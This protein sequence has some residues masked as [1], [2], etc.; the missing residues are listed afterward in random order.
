MYIYFVTS[1]RGRFNFQPSYLTVLQDG[2]ATEQVVVTLLPLGAA[3]CLVQRRLKAPAV[4]PLASVVISISSGTPGRLIIF[5]KT[6][7]SVPTSNQNI[8][9]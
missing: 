6:V 7:I 5:V 1:L 8:A 3:A 4:S 9:F 2:V